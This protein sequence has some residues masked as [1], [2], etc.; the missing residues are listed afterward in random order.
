VARATVCCGVASD[1]NHVDVG[2]AAHQLGERIALDRVGGDVDAGRYRPSQISAPREYL[3]D[4]GS[5]RF[6]QVG[7]S[8]APDSLVHDVQQRGGSLG[9][10]Q[11]GGP[12]GVGVFNADQDL[13][14]H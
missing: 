10:P 3:L 5:G 12:A 7:A 4:G 9:C 14:L 6:D 11:Y 8:R 13:I 1:N 2:G